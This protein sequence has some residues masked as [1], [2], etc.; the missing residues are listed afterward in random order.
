MMQSAVIFALAARDERLES[1]VGLSQWLANPSHPS[2]LTRQHWLADRLFELLPETALTIVNPGFFADLPYM[3]LMK[4]AALLGVYPMPANGSSIET[5]RR[6][7]TTSRASRSPRSSIQGN[8]PA[9]ATV[10]RVPSF[11]H[12]TA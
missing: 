5:L 11:F 8:T 3:A 10:R 4:Y 6:R 1:I 2:L 12:L 7:P 9:R